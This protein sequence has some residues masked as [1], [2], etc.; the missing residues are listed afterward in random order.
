MPHAANTYRAHSYEQDRRTA[1]QRGYN[2]RWDKCSKLYLAAHPLCKMCE[3]NG[4][5]KLATQTDHIIPHRGDRRLFW[6]HDNWQP[7]CESCHSAKTAH[8]G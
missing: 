3:A 1:R 4:V 5:V 7:L 8:G 6:D 2:S